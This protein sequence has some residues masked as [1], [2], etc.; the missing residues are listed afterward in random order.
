VGESFKLAL[1][2]D[3][4]DLAK[5]AMLADGEELQALGLSDASRLDLAEDHETGRVRYTHLRV[6]PRL[7]G[8]AHRLRSSQPGEAT[9]EY[10]MG[11]RSRSMLLMDRKSRST[12]ARLL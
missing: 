5:P 1:A 6:S 2:D 12:R 9:G 10:R 8:K 11:R 3:T 7:S 4:N